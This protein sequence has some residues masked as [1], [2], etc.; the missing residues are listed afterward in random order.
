MEEV[1]LALVLGG[2]LVCFLYCYSPPKSKE[3]EAE[4]IRGLVNEALAVS[5]DSK[6]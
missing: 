5:E 4:Y 6:A 1:V 2:L 3:E